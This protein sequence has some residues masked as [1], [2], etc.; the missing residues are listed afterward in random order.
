MISVEHVISEQFP[1]IQNS[2]PLIK[3]SCLRFLRFLFHEQ[4][5]QGFASEYPHMV[6][7]D[8][9]EQVLEY[10]NFDF[11]V[12]DSELRNI[13]NT[14]RVV[15]IANHPIGSLDGLVLLKMLSKIRQDVKVVANDMLWAIKPLR[16]ML[17][18]VNN[19]GNKT[20]KENM[21]NIEQHLVGGGALLIFPAG[22]VSR[23]SPTGIKDGKWHSGFLRFAKKTQSP[24]LPIHVDGKNSSFFYGLSMLA[25]PLSTM[26]LVHEMFKQQSKEVR[27]RVAPPVDFDVYANLPIEDRQKVK[28]FK[29]H[30]YAIRKHKHLSEFDPKLQS[31]AH[32]EPSRLIRNELREHQR[33]GVTQDGKHIYCFKHQ[34]DSAVMR[35]VG[36]LRELTFRSVGEGSGKVRDIDIYDRLYDHILL[37]DDEEMEIV[38]AYRMS[39]TARLHQTNELYTQTLF[40]FEQLPKQVLEQGLE[41]GR[42]FVQPKYWGKRSLDYLW[43]GIGAYLKQHPNIRY[44]LGA[45]S[46]SNDLTG[47]AKASLVRFYQGYFGNK[48]NWVEAKLPYQPSPEL[49]VHFTG[50]DYASEFVELKAYLKQQGCNVPTLYKQYA[51]LCESGGTQFLSF[52]RDPDFCDC[53]DGFVLVDIKRMKQA[54]KERYLEPHSGSK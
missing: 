43:Q 53:I 48:S 12:K 36:R 18:P 11:V 19:M 10:L 29:K 26:W 17:L 49:G 46:I 22:E 45:V 1:A 8:F 9:V 40:S 51:E 5:F 21:A 2:N 33:I 37:W 52:N 6:G 7:T 24:I 38:G 13:P 23:L 50:L 32:P 25:K 28:L 16:S 41:L 44:L 34:T 54:K 20:P 4:E 47:P 35:E 39:P 42:S 15:V 31:I 14:G 30:V 3:N 27:V